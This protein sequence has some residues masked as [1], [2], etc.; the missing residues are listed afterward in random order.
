MKP[1]A[2]TLKGCPPGRALASLTHNNEL[3][4]CSCDKDNEHILSCEPNGF[5]VVL[6]V[7]DMYVC[8]C[9]SCTC[10]G[11]WMVTLFCFVV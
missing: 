7:C 5:D 2:V 9:T 4:Q 3:F 11:K 6:K 1:I 8:S 10:S